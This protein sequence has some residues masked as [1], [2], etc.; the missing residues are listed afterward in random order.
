M[1]NLY[2]P[3]LGTIPA[4]VLAAM[5]AEG[6][7]PAPYVPTFKE[8]GGAIDFVRPSS[9][10]GVR[11]FT[12]GTLN[13]TQ[14]QLTAVNQETTQ[15]VQVDYA[16]LNDWIVNRHAPGALVRLPR[17]WDAGAG[18]GTPIDDYTAWVPMPG[19]PPAVNVNVTFPPI[20]F[21]AYQ[22]VPATPEAS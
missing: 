20:E 6:A 13:N 8:S 21:P 9:L 17:G 18:Q 7:T 5:A 11:S 12:A 14:Q 22:P 19:S 2:Q 3:I 15:I 4:D 16:D 10:P 1:I